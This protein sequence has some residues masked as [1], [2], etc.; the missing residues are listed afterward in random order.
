M[1]GILH[2]ACV[3][4][5]WVKVPM[6]LAVRVRSGAPWWFVI[7]SATALG[8]ILSNATVY[9]QNLAV[10]DSVKVWVSYKPFTGLVY[11]PFYL[12]CCALP[13]WLI[14]GRQS[15]AGGT[16]PIALLAMAV[17]VIE[18]AAIV[19]DAIRR[20]YLDNM[21]RNADPFIWPP[22]TIAAAFLLSWVLTTVLQRSGRRI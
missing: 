22:V 16:I 1:L 6:L 12:L 18:W 17:L 11:G 15:S 8:W 2:L 13:Y 3:A 5:F 7:L 19:G 20:G 10:D 4:S 14:F 21:L 9:F